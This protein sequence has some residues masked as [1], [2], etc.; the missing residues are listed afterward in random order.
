ML[1]YF[2]RSEKGIRG[3]TRE[4]I[5]TTLNK[6]INGAKSIKRA[7]P[8]PTLKIMEDFV[9]VSSVEQ[10]QKAWRRFSDAVCRVAE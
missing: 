5:V 4:T 3:R 2:E 6:D 7:F 8:I 1:F 9:H 10:D